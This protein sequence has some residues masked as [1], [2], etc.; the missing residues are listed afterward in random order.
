LLTVAARTYPPYG[1]SPTA[2]YLMFAALQNLL[3]QVNIM[4]YDLSG[5]YPGWVTWFNSPIYDGGYRFPSSGGLVPSVDGSVG[6]FIA[7]GMSPAKLGIGIAFYGYVWTGASGTPTGG[8]TQPRQSWVVA[9]TATAFA[10]DDLM[11]DYY[12]TNLYHWDLSAQAAWLS[13]TNANPTNDAFIKAY[14]EYAKRKGLA[15][16]STV[17]TNDPMEATYVGIHMWK[18]AVEKGK[19]TDTDKVITAMSGQTF[20]APSGFELMMD[21]TNHHLHKPVFIG[22]IRPDGQFNVVW[23]TKEPIRA[24]PWSPFVPGNESKQNM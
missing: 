14:K 15:N 23:K 1:D 12:Q 5:P 21:P 2:T 4:T 10:Y 18:Q 19:S 7:N 6:N 3:D 16:A 17:V 8:V 11:A 9:P 20:K 24:Q 13:I 22:E